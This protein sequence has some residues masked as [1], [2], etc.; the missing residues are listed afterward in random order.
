M[1]CQFEKLL[2][3]RTADAA[4]IDYMIA[5]YRPLEIIRD[6]DG[7]MLSEVKAVGYCLPIAEMVR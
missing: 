5:V 4:T 1:L 3:P 7:D 6:S 2:Y